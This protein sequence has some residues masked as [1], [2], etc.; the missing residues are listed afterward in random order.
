MKGYVFSRQ[1]DKFMASFWMPLSSLGEWTWAI[2]KISVEV[3]VK[4]PVLNVKDIREF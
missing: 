4:K 1:N 2:I 3:K